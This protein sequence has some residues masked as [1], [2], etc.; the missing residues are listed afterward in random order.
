MIDL[1]KALWPFLSEIFFGGKSIK[2]VVLKNKLTTFLLV[3]AC[4]SIFLNWTLLG[5]FYDIA[6]ARREE[7]AK[8]VATKPVQEKPHAPGDLIPPSQASSAPVGASSPDKIRE[9]ELRR[10]RLKDIFKD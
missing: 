3:V 10:Q 5:K 6:V 7:R 1:V 8:E 2:E 4:A 9:D